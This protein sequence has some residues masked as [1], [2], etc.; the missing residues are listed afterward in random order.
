MDI[1]VKCKIRDTVQSMAKYVHRVVNQI[2]LLNVSLETNTTEY[3][4]SVISSGIDHSSPAWILSLL[5]SGIEI[6]NKLDTGAQ[7]NIM[8]KKDL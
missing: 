8:S 7:C 6:S 3:F 5:T 1:V 2:T 4:I